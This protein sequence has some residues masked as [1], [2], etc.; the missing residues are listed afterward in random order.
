VAASTEPA[1][2]A[3]DHE[4]GGDDQHPPQGVDRQSDASEK[5][6]YEQKYDDQSHHSTSGSSGL[7]QIYLSLRQPLNHFLAAISQ[8]YFRL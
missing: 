6:G 4:R 1:Y 7:H 8:V 3:D 5:E 2:C